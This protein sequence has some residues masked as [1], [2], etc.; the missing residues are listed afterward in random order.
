M[1]GVAVCCLVV[2]AHGAA[3]Q[4]AKSGK[5]RSHTIALPAALTAALTREGCRVPT[6]PKEYAADSTS[7][8]P[9]V[10]YRAS[11]RLVAST[12]WVVICERTSRRDVLVFSEPIT[13]E[14]QPALQLNIEWD[15]N[16]D[17]CEGWIEIAD[18]AWVR[19]A[20]GK[21][22]SQGNEE[23]LAPSEIKAVHAGIIDSMCEG[24]GV[25]I[26]YWTGRR[27]VSLPA[28]WDELGTARD[29]SRVTMRPGPTRLDANVHR[30]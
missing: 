26:R 19:L 16:D 1:R 11:V 27:W 6:P 25:R 29:S 10:V 24:D 5:P 30:R 22:R 13:T 20:I 7:V 3:S 17:G 21:E 8:I 28:Y 2:W 14:S 15:P 9:R 18:S 12:D 4:E 23:R